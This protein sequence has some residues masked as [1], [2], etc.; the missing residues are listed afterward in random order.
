MLRNYL[1]QIVY[2]DREYKEKKKML[3]MTNLHHKHRVL[4]LRQLCVTLSL[5]RE[6]SIA[7]IVRLYGD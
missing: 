6:T 5:Y 2:N 1:P 4:N 7:L 3:T